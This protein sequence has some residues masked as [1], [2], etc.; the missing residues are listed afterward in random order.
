MIAPQELKQNNLIRDIESGRI[1]AVLTIGE[2][3]CTIKMPFSKLSQSYEEF[4]PIELTED[5]LLKLGFEK[6]DDGS[7]SHQY[8]YG[9]NPVTHDYL[10]YLIWIKDPIKDDLPKYPFYLNGHFEMKTVH[11]LQN[12]F[13]SLFGEELK[14]KES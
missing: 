8:S 10:V 7:V 6:H 14:I 2:K 13:H 9:F 3:K 5:W 4:E 1:G 11:Q 12:L